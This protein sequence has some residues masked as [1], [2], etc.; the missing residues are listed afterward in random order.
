MK[1]PRKFIVKEDGVP[2]A[3]EPLR[4]LFGSEL[5]PMKGIVVKA[6][7]PTLF[8]GEKFAH[9][10]IMQARDLARKLHESLVGDWEKVA[11][12]SRRGKFTIESI[13]Q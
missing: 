2:C 13:N 11:P 5:V 4:G 12:Y 7:E 10:A 1:K 8:P 9:R 6:T 3:L